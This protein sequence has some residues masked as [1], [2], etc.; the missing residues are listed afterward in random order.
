MVNRH[1]FHTKHA[2]EKYSAC[3]HLWDTPIFESETFVAIPT[4]GALVAGWLL[5]VPRTPALSFASLPEASFP[6]LN[7]FLVDIVSILQPNYGPVALFEHG[8]SVVGDRIGCGV[9]YAHLH[10]VPTNCDLER[11]ARTL[12]PNIQWSQIESLVDIRKCEVAPHGYWYL[13]QRFGDS[14]PLIGRAVDGNGPSQ[15]FRKIIA[16]HLG[17]LAAY[18]W[19]E[20]LGEE[21]IAATVGRLVPTLSA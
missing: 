1:T 15:L 6:E 14:C 9:D 21:E 4:V 11:G 18:D 19:K 10:L 5:V 8:P 12:A 2:L 7:R 3:R 13:Q 16:T 17:A 20:C